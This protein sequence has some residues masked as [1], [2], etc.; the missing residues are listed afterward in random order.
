MKNRWLLRIL[1][2][3]VC[4]VLI[5]GLCACGQQSG[6]GRT[7]KEQTVVVQGAGQS[8]NLLDYQSYYFGQVNNTLASSSSSS[9]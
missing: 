9:P 5:L 6:I 2:V 4:L 7:E 1:S 3:S 8:I